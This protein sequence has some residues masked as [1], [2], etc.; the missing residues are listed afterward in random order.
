LRGCVG[1]GSQNHLLCQLTADACGRPVVAGPVEATALGNILVH[2]VASG[3]LPDIS[4][5]RRA[6][7]ASFPLASFEP[8]PAADWDAAIAR[9][10]ALLVL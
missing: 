8:Q 1:G 9:F 4:A 2:P 10:K 3:Y 6:V 7:A 5:G